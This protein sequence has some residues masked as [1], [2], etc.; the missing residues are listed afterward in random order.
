MKEAQPATIWLKDY[1][2]PDYWIDTTELEFELSPEATLVTAKLRFRLNNALHAS[3]TSPLPPLVLDG[4]A[5][6]LVSVAVDD[7]TL[8]ADDYTIADDKLQLQPVAETFETCI[9]TR[10]NP[11]ANRALEGLYSSGSLYCTQCEAEGFRRITYYLDRPDVMSVFTTRIIADSK[12][13]PVLLSNGNRIA[14]QPLDDGRQSVTW[15]DPFKKPAYLF[16]LVAG[17]LSCVED[18]FTTMNGR[19]VTLQIFTEPHNI[20]KCDHAMRS[21]KKAMRW[22]EEVYGREY[23]LDVFMIVAVDDFN[24]GAMENKG[25]NI[26]NSSCVLA[27]PDTATD[28][29]FQLIEAIVAHEYFHNWSGNR[30]TC[31]DWFQ[32]S[33]KEGLTVFRDAMFSADMNS[34]TVKRIEDVNVLRTRQFAE[35]AGPM[36]HPVR[37]DNF[38]EISNFYTVTVYEKGAEVV[39]MIHNIVGRE[40]FR[41][42]TDLYFERHDGQAVTTEDFV[43][44]MEDANQVDLKQFRRWYSQAGTPAVHVTDSF[45]ASTGDYSLTFRQSRPPVPGQPTCEPFHIPVAMGLLDSEG[46]ALPVTPEGATTRVLDIKEP[47]QTLVFSGLSAK[48]L[49]SLL[50]DFS[51][52]VRLEYDYSRD[53]LML[54]MAHD[55]DGFIRWDSSQKLAADVILELVEHLQQGKALTMEP[56]LVQAWGSLL[57]D[58]ADADPAL[59]AELFCLPSEA[60]LA[61]L[62]DEVDVDNIH[63][64]RKFVR[65]ELALALEEPLL[66]RFQKLSG[67]EWSLDARAMGERSLKNTCLAFLAAL[68]RPRAVELARQQYAD[69]TNMTDSLAALRILVGAEHSSAEAAAAEALAD[70][71]TRWAKD[72]N[73]M[74]LW[75]SA[76]ASGPRPGALGRVKELMSHPAFDNKNPNK[77]RALLSAFCDGNPV[78]FHDRSGAGYALLEKELLRIDGFNPQLAARLTSPLTFWRRYDKDRQ[79]LMRAVLERLKAQKLSPDLFEVVSKSLAWTG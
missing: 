69:A 23:D 28:A 22:D 31:R 63:K 36:A 11:L 32:L 38:I 45:D 61:E 70:F 42:G 77:M 50:R 51:A 27:R 56:R 62:M 60:W 73:V 7:K 57:G 72:T 75:F 76:Q 25:L 79:D 35:D 20:T 13:C 30:V 55:E 21:L 1:K 46:R 58:L 12:K 29:R 52:P 71:A 64:A 49:P 33:L 5:L 53:D 8:S 43:R 6:E 67:K 39:R 15:H 2:Q 48:P 14:Q 19:V 16:A 10:I 9:Q 17:D 40:G 68:D 59:V 3:G 4:Q 41:K 54:L 26:F 44:A 37:P 18:S 47:E 66:Q 74:D 24:M 65:H 34:A 78:Q